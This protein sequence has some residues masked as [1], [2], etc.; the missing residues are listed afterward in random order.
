M[1]LRLSPDHHMQACAHTHKCTHTP[2]INVFLG[3]H[4]IVWGCRPSGMSYGGGHR[5]RWGVCRVCEIKWANES[6]NWH[7][8]KCQNVQAPHSLPSRPGLLLWAMEEASVC[9][10][11]AFLSLGI[12]EAQLLELRRH[13]QKEAKTLPCLNP[14]LWRPKPPAKKPTQSRR[15]LAGN[16]DHPLS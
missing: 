10:E 12:Y 9:W 1:S 6:R 7:S 5:M 3:V 14:Q 2:L 11:M 4:V 16:K 13:R 15:Q 8:V